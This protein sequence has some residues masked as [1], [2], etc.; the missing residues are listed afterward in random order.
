VQF[1]QIYGHEETKKLLIG[2]VQNRHVA[3]A[4][5]FLG[6]QG[7]PNLAL[8]LAYATLINCENPQL[9]DSCGTCASCSKMNKLIH[10]DFNFIFP[11]TTTKKEPKDPSSQK[12]MPDWREF[13]QQSPYQ[14]LYEWMQFI[15]AENKQGNISREESRHLLRLI[16]LKPFEAAFK[17]IVIWLPELM[18]APAANALLKMLEE[19]PGQTIF[20]LVAHDVERLLATI[21]SRTQIMKIRPFTEQEVVAWLVERQAVNPAVAGQIAQLAEGNLQEAVRLSS[22]M[23]SDYF[24]FFVGW[25]RSCYGYKFGEIVEKSEE[26]Q[27]LGRESQK[28]LLQY[29]L[30][31][32]RRVMLYGID[33]ALVVFVP[34]A[35][36]DFISKFSR[37][38]HPGNASLMAEELNQAHYHIERNAN[39]KMVFVD[40]SLHM[41]RY[42]KIPQQERVEEV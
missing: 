30:N 35:E 21:L 39:P 10:P 40:T 18:Q 26:F 24:T 37:F 28:I 6:P 1:S 32:V 38:I 22:Q 29:A 19:P 4:Q 17:I 23:T 7:S 12:F 15:R 33:P 42:L 34:A 3:H 27:K 41:A 2:S 31:T 20:L 5:L 25:M 9:E 11:V 14:S 8:A 13:I 36:L 16:T